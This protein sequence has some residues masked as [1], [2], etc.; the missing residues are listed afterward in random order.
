M[1]AGRP[2][3]FETPEAMEAKI[4]EY[5]AERVE[6]ETAHREPATI[7]GLILYLGF[8]HRE[9]LADY[10]KREGF[11]DIVRKA[12][13]RVENRYEQNLH[14]T[15]PTGSIFALKNMGWKDKH[16]T[17]LSGGIGVTWNETK[18]YAPKPEAD[19]GT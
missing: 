6:K 15:T 14:G 17:E 2:P 9:A 4:E 8:S 18:T 11:S 3:I 19:P 12:R 5:F 1:P 7:T 16:E 13:L 10:E